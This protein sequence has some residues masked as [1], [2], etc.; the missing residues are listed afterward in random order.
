[1]PLEPNRMKDVFLA[2]LDKAAPADRAAYLDQACAG[3]A[4]LR[5]KVEAMLQAHEQPDA[6]LDHP[7]AEHLAGKHDSTLDF[8]EPPAKEG[9]LGRLGHYEVLELVGRGGM[10]IVLRAF[11]EKLHRIIAIKALAPHLAGNEKARKLFDR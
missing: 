8:L 11:D 9:S 2:A 6:L 5:R 1:M 10:G 3:D 7:A 4:N